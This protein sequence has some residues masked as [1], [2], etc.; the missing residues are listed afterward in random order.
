[1]KLFTSGEIIFIQN[2]SS[3]KWAK[4]AFNKV[5]TLKVVS[6]T[7]MHLP[8]FLYKNVSLSNDLIFFQ[9][10]RGRWLVTFCWR[11][12]LIIICGLFICYFTYPNF[13]LWPLDQEFPTFLW[14]SAYLSNFGLAGWQTWLRL[15][16]LKKL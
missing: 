7:L 12:V 10:W 16:L 9:R 6:Y 4:Y 13:L 8:S 14:P 5:W 11:K 15:P 3:W 2:I 1:M